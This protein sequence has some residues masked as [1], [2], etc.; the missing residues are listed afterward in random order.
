MQQLKVLCILFYLLT[1]LN[2]FSPPG[3]TVCLSTAQGTFY[4]STTGLT[5]PCSVSNVEFCIP[6]R[7]SYC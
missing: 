4:D 2:I 6:V 5:T 7:L 3:A 1:P